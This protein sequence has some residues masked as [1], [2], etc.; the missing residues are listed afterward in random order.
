LVQDD[1]EL[2]VIPKSIQL[3]AGRTGQEYN[4][5]K[6]RKGACWEDRYHA[7]AVETGD[8][9]LRCL[10]YIDLNMVRA[11]VVKHPLEWIFGGYIEIQSPRRKCSLIAYRN[12][13]ALNGFKTYEGFR[14]AHRELVEEK[15][16]SVN[17]G[18]QSE[19]SQSI[20][21]GS[22]TF[23][24]E[25]KKKTLASWQKE[26]RRLGKVICFSYESP[27]AFITPILIQKS[28][29]LALRT[30]ISGGLVKHFR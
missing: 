9:L 5:R 19:W 18:Y 20:A 6:K 28:K 26:G 12:L 30:P 7:T 21:V 23:I 4:K 10:V 8:H 13:A 11:G 14:E 17:N 27:W 3:V 1:G 2:H 15:L 22:K 29:I 24:E 25:I 16:R